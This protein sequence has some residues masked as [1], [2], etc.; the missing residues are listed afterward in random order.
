M[1]SKPQK[2][3][4]G[5]ERRGSPVFRARAQAAYE[6]LRGLISEHGGADIAKDL[7]DRKTVEDVMR[8]KPEMVGALLDSAWKLRTNSKL[9]EYFLLADGEGTTVSEYD[10]VIAPCGRT[11]EDTIQSHLYGSARLYMMRRENDW[12]RERLSQPHKLNR[13]LTSGF[14]NTMRVMVGMKAKVDEKALRE[15]YPGKGLYETLKPYLLVQAQFKYVPAYADLSTKGAAIIGDIF[16]NLRS[17]AAIKVACV[18]EPDTLMNAR[19]CATA[20]AESEF[21]TQAAAEKKDSGR[22]RNI[23]ELRRDVELS[24][25]VKKRTAEVFAHILNNHVESLAFVERHQAGAEAVVRALAPLYVDETWTI[26]AEE[27]AV[28]NVINCPPNVAASIGKDARYVA[29]EVSQAIMQLQY[30][31]IGRDIL[32]ILRSQLDDDAYM[33]ALGDEAAIKVWET[34][35]GTFNNQFKYQHD[36]KGDDTTIK[37]FKYLT[38]ESRTVIKEFKNALGVLGG[39]SEDSADG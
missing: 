39:S 33:R 31:D 1:A 6:I 14:A 36:A 35:P 25:K 34:V 13:K 21:F 29:V 12:T 28:E 38:A 37:N 22:K 11:Y 17:T 19:S 4:G 16:E 20:Y 26:L 7:A 18:L 32:K 24:C 9:S 27:G 8:T 23:N 30:P 10:Q 2:Q 15:S 3:K 5:N